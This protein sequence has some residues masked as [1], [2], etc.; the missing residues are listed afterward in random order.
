MSA[1]LAWAGTVL[2]VWTVIHWPLC[3]LSHLWPA[4]LGAAL[5]SG[6]ATLP[7]VVHLLVPLAVCACGLLAGLAVVRAIDPPELDDASLLGFGASFGLGLVGT[8][9]ACLSLAGCLSARS[10][11]ITVAALGLGGAWA[12]RGGKAALRLI[13]SVGRS[14][15]AAAA[16]EGPVGWVALGLA[17]GLLLLSL[18]K[19]MVPPWFPDALYYQLTLPRLYLEASGFAR[20]PEMPITSGY[21]GLGQMLFSTALACG[22]D[23]VAAVFSWVHLPLLALATALVGRDRALMA[24]LA[25]FAVPQLSWAACVP[26][27]DVATGA[28][29]SFALYATLRAWRPGAGRWGLMAALSAGF[30]L[31]NKYLAGPAVVILLATVVLRAAWLEGGRRGASTAAVV[32]LIAAAPFAPWAVRN[33]LHWGT[34]VFPFL[35]PSSLD[36]PTARLLRMSHSAFAANSGAASLVWLPIDLTFLAR[37][38]DLDAYQGEVGPLPL[39]LLVLPVVL[40]GPRPRGRALGGYALLLFVVWAYWSRQVRF[41]F[42]LLPPLFAACMA[43]RPRDPALGAALARVVTAALVLA[44]AWFVGYARPGY[45]LPYLVGRESRASY[46]RTL[47]QTSAL[48]AAYETLSREPASGKVMFFREYRAYLCP[49]PALFEHA[50][51]LFDLP[52]EPRA[53]LA[54]MRALGVTHLLVNRTMWKDAIAA[55]E[56]WP[57]QTTLEAVL[58]GAAVQQIEARG[59]AAGRQEVELY[60]LLGP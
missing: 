31:A 51:T 60:R 9:L 3:S 37:R 59:P 28:H 41:L 24:A 33:Q 39:A 55:R 7:P 36:A 32:A 22:W 44:L 43:G 15:L 29:L 26:L 56:A 12:G 19:A 45:D 58:A 46:Y 48:W 57:F 40:A 6:E 49:R 38:D 18:C 4:G 11:A 34:P 30:A 23:D 47:H 50:E 1:W 53:A 10:I 35:L 16:R 13:P 5:A 2:C 52:H 42:P 8:A 25:L 27:V 21:P 54:R 20:L 14:V 17:A